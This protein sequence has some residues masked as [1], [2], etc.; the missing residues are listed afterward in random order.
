[1]FNIL[2]LLK[3]FMAMTYIQ[4]QY[5]ILIFQVTY[6]YARAGCTYRSLL[7]SSVSLFIWPL[8]QIMQ[9]QDKLIG[10]DDEYDELYSDLQLYLALKGA[11]T[12]LFLV[13]SQKASFY[14]ELFSLLI[15]YLSAL[16]TTDVGQFLTIGTSPPA[17]GLN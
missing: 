11:C 8:P 6:I 10:D 7:K 5:S 16:F 4:F 15:F 14:L 1:M 13:T 17:D 9:C 12:A 3:K 2:N